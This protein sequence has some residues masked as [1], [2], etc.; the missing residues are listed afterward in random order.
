MEHSRPGSF[1]AMLQAWITPCSVPGLDHS[2]ECSRP[3]TFWQKHESPGNYQIRVPTRRY[4]HRF[5][6]NPGANNV[7][8]HAQNGLCFFCSEGWGP[9]EINKKKQNLLKNKANVCKC[10]KATIIWGGVFNA[11]ITAI[12]ITTTTTTTTTTTARRRR[13]R[14]EEEEEEEDE[15]EEEE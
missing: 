7:G 4:T 6:Q 15:E 1:H 9:T 8:F 3:A 11:K 10:M 14:R 2:M 13:R 12:T 5:V